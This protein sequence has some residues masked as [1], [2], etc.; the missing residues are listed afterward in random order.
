M[1]AYFYG[2]LQIKPYINRETGR[3]KVDKVALSRIAKKG[4]KGSGEAKIILKMRKLK[5]LSGTYFSVPMDNDNHLRCAYKIAGTDSGR[6]SS[7]KTF[8]GTGTNLQNQ[9]PA[10]KKFLYPEKGYYLFE[11]DLTERQKRG[12][13]TREKSGKRE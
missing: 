6:L 5:K 1:I 3:P 11:P 8:F 13:G 12:L 10:F 7:N 9:P 2:E 4:L